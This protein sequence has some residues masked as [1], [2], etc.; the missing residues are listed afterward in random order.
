MKPFANDL[1]IKA[2]RQRVCWWFIIFLSVGL[3]GFL[4]GTKT[5]LPG[6]ST[7]D[8]IHAN[9]GERL[10]IAAGIPP[11]DALLLVIG[12]QTY[13]LEDA[14]FKARVQTLINLLQALKLPDSNKPIF[15]KIQG[16]GHTLIGDEHYSSPDNHHALV[17]A[18]SAD[19]VD[20]T[21]TTSP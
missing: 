4:I 2:P 20:K 1:L 11:K 10:A 17:I 6:P 5:I 9:H 14:S 12:S 19:S 16:F 21:L 7:S 3:L 18:H 13:T 8:T 15:D